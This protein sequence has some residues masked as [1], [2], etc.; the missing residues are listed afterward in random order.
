ME[1]Y[2]LFIY[3]PAKKDLD[4]MSG[5]LLERLERAILGLAVEPRPRGSK[6]LAGKGNTLRLRAGDYRILYE[7][8]DMKKRV[9][10]YRVV[11]RKEAYR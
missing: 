2:T 7:I 4:K 10:I 1:V 3:P 6:K 11:H 5:K 9:S 8:D